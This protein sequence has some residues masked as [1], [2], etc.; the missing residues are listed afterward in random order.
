MAV[1]KGVVIVLDLTEDTARVVRRLYRTV[2]YVAGKVSEALVVSD[3]TARIRG[4]TPYA[5]GVCVVRDDMR[6]VVGIDRT[7]DA[8]GPVG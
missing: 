1:R 4:R 3:N 5:P 8:A 6:I 2:V 7:R